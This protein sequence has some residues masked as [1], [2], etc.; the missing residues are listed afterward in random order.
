MNPANFLPSP[1]ALATTT[2]KIASKISTGSVPAWCFLSAFCLPLL[3]PLPK[4]PSSQLSPL[5]SSSTK[6]VDDPH[7][8]E[9]DENNDDGE[10]DNP[11]EGNGDCRRGGCGDAELASGADVGSA[12]SRLPNPITPRSDVVSFLDSAIFL[13]C[14]VEL[15]KIPG[16]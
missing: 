3:L 16:S 10:G 6:R 4:S 1:A 15:P 2:S 8:D 13:C 14:H 9:D 12:T 11:C 7:D 5:S